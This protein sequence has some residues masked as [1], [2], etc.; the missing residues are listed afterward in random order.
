MAASETGLLRPPARPRL[1]RAAAEILKREG[2][3]FELQLIGDGPQ[4]PELEAIIERTRLGDCVQITG[5]LQG[6][7]FAETLDRVRVV[8]M[9]SVWE[10]TAGLAAIE[11][12]MRGRLVIASKIGGLGEVVGDAGLTCLPGNPED[13]ARCMRGALQDSSKVAAIGFEAR[14][15]ARDLFLSG[16]MIADHARI[17]VELL[18][19]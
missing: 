19:G 8:V 5:F 3:K 18:R 9:P 1:R 16:R 14:R 13:L 2:H 17:Y 7:A 10:E 6:A 11:Q 15:R 4:R 12:M